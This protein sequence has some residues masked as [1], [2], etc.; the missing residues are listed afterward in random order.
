MIYWYK[1]DRTTYPTWPAGRRQS[2]RQWK[3]KSCASQPAP[4]W[5]NSRGMWPHPR[6][7]CRAV[8]THCRLVHLQKGGG[9]GGGEAGRDVDVPKLARAALRCLPTQTGTNFALAPMV[10]RCWVTR[11]QLQGLICVLVRSMTLM[12]HMWPSLSMLS[13]RSGF[14]D[15]FSCHRSAETTGRVYI[16]IY[17]Y[18]HVPYI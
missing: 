18:R 15:A 1:S 6:C 7:D 5:P 3:S 12:W 2:S 8:D 9:G 17:R 11:W 4:R 16:H 10:I 14:T 13:S